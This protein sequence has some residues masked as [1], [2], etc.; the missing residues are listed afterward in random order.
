M[1]D[2]SSLD[3][4]AACDAG[5]EIELLHPVNKTPLGIF[6]KVL[7]KDS[8]V[9]K[10]H[11]RQSLNDRLAK[12]ASAKRRGKDLEPSTI[13]D[14][15]REGLEA[16]AVCTVGWWSVDGEERVPTIK[17]RGQDLPFTRENVKMLYAALPWIKQQVDEG[18]GDLANFLKV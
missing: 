18:I 16:L 12:Q 10:G 15:E 3:T 17:F 1:L 13:E 4:V 6:I 9:F 7:G 14:G 11:L 2:L 8:A 5:A